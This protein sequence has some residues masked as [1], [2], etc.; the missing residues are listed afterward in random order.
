MET[1]SPYFDSFYHTPPPIPPLLIEGIGTGKGIGIGKTL[2]LTSPPL[3]FFEI[4]QNPVYP[5]LYPPWRIDTRDGKGDNNINKHHD[6]NLNEEKENKQK[7]TNKDEDEKGTLFASDG[8]SENVRFLATRTTQ[9]VEASKASKAIDIAIKE[10]SVAK[11]Q[12]KSTYNKNELKLA[13]VY[14]DDASQLQN[15]PVKNKA[16]TKAIGGENSI[17]IP[18]STSLQE[19]LQE[20]LQEIIYPFPFFH[21]IPPSYV[22]SFVNRNRNRNKDVLEKKDKDKELK[23]ESTTTATATTKFSK[24]KGEIGSFF[25]HD[26][27]VLQDQSSSKQNRPPYEDRCIIERKEIEPEK[28]V[29]S[30]KEDSWG[31]KYTLNPIW[32]DF[33]SRKVQSS[34]T[35]VARSQTKTRT[36]TRKEKKITSK[37]K[38][39]KKIRTKVK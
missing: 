35:K 27:F 7:T 10:F 26:K 4:E 13:Y 3:S 28:T 37:K 15:T 38:R 5:Y 6:C 22:L 32:A 34:K 8:E 33:F 1:R 16:E 12:E 20:T 2:P 14:N 24:N 31:Y 17:P 23:L 21:H 18:F 39:W 19:T 9:K 11:E 36:K 29:Q 25:S 30:K